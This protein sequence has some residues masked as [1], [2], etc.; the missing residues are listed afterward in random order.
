[1][2]LQECRRIPTA[3]QPKVLGHQDPRRQLFPQG[4]SEQ[5]TSTAA[6]PMP[7]EA[8]P[9]PQGES[10]GEL[11]GDGAESRSHYFSLLVPG[12]SHFTMFPQADASVAVESASCLAML[13]GMKAKPY[14][15]KVVIPKTQTCSR[16]QK[17][18]WSSQSSRNHDKSFFS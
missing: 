11:S 8:P 10:H 15:G 13:W 3:Q 12:T 2:N 5:R 1:M 4:R 16:C 17:G 7:G 18:D 6:P 9:L 14:S